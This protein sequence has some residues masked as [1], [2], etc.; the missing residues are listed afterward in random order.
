M[1][2]PRPLLRLEDSFFGRHHSHLATAV[3]TAGVLGLL[4]VPVSPWVLDLSIGASFL[5]S[6]LLLTATLQVRRAS[7]LSE[8]SRPCSW[9]A[10]LL[11]L[12]IS[13]ASTR[14]I[15]LE[16]RAGDIIHAVGTV[17]AGANVVVG[18]VVFV[19]LGVVQFIVIAKGGDRVAEVAARFTLDS[20]PGRQMS[21]DADLRSGLLSASQAGQRRREM[22]RETYLYGAMDGAMKFVKGDSIATFL[23]AAVNLA[24]GIAVGMLQRGLPFSEAARSCTILTIGDGLVAQIPRFSAPWRR[25]SHY[26]RL[27]DRYRGRRR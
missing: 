8:L 13:I 17:A 23:V 4:V 14:M 26:P 6:L 1:R 7:D 16:A 27:R 22:E 15:L 18:L 19:V 24:G 2:L 12:A 3:V 11:R 9:G 25:P 21:V 5:V 20:I 10:T